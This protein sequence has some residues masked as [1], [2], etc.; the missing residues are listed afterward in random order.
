[1]QEQVKAGPV[2]AISLEFP[3]DTFHEVHLAVIRQGVS[4]VVIKRREVVQRFNVNRAGMVRN[5]R[6]VHVKG[7]R[8]IE[9]AS[10]PF[11]GV[12]RDI[13]SPL[14]QNSHEA[15]LLP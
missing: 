12:G 1:M 4:G 9:D 6:P 3:N 5:H 2:K 10:T 11:F 15:V 7:D 13:C 8:G 14:P